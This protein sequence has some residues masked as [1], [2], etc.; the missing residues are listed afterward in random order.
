MGKEWD[1]NIQTVIIVETE[2]IV[3]NLLQHYG[4]ERF[5]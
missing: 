3:R 4:D 1:I 5:E 2:L